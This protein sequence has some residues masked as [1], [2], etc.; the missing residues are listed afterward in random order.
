[1][2]GVSTFV[3][4]ASVA[5]VAFAYF[6]FPCLIMVW[7]VLFPKPI[8]RK[9]IT[10]SIS[11]IV[12]AYNEERNIIA[13]LENAL[14]LDYPADSLEIIVASDGSDDET[15]N[16]VSAYASQGV[17]LLKL[18][19]RGKVFALNAAVDQARGEILVFSDAN[20][21]YHRLALRS[22]ARNFADP[23]VGG[24]AGVTVYSLMADSESSSH[25]EDAYWNYDNWLK[26]R[27]S[28]T[29]SV[30]SAHGGI[31][32]IRR[33]LYPRLADSA[34]TD[35]FAISTAVIEQDY[36]LVFEAEA[37]SCEEAVTT[38]KH[39]FSRKV[40]IV[41]QG[42]RAL[43]MR[44]RL[45]NPFRYGFYSMVLFGHKVLRR[46]VPV[47]LVVIFTSAVLASFGDKLFLYG[48]LAQVSF[49]LLA[50]IGFLMRKAPWG[51]SKLFYLPFFYC[52]ANAAALVALLKL[53]RGRRIELWQPQRHEV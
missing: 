40:R 53:V 14:S 35:D 28:L 43:L 23:R 52:M 36:R 20:S 9:P 22:L 41:T 19:R 46:L 4:W 44:Q 45:L 31:Y 21:I 30:V 29:G 18:P 49:Y 48:V 6:G 16:L 32:A 47:L 1:V 13:R 3:F 5:I 38:A 39:E 25:G 7:G 15:E 50:L 2:A 33:R 34:V 42:W 51:R 11:L 12:A 37:I 10:P 8:A 26:E 24:V 17:R 27:E